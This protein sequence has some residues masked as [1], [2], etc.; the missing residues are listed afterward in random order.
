MKISPFLRRYKTFIITGCISIIGIYFFIKLLFYLIGPNV[1]W[2]YFD[3]GL[4][5][6]KYKLPHK[7]I[8]Y[9]RKTI[10]IDPSNTKAYVGLGLA[11]WDIEDKEKAI[12]YFKKSLFTKEKKTQ[13]FI[14]TI[15][16]YIQ[17]LQDP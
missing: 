12:T 16:N 8:E 3:L 11:Y 13:D 14:F 1:A 4:E 7:T 6:A 15:I 9:F 5:A 2:I 10:S 17:Q